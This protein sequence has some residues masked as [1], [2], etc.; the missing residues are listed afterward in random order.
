MG[1]TLLHG[2]R[3]RSWT[4]LRGPGVATGGRHGPSGTTG[5][6]PGPRGRLPVTAVRHL[7]LHVPFC[8]HRCPYCD[9]PVVAGA[10]PGASRW[11]SALASELRLR[12]AAGLDLSDLE[13]LLVGGGTPSYLRA[14]LVEGVEAIVGA[15]R[16]GGLSEWTVEVN[17]EDVEGELLECWCEAGVT[18][19]HI[20][21]QSLR[22]RALEWL[23]RGHSP[24][25][26]LA[27]MAAAERAGVRSWGVDVLFGLPLEFD[28]DPTLTLGK[29]I[30]AGAPHVSLYELA[31]EPGTPL[32]AQRRR[33]R[34]VPAGD[35]LVADQY[36]AC[37][38]VLG[39]AGYE[40]YEMTSFA[41]PSHRPLH[42]S[43]VLRE[44]P[45]LGLGPGAHSRVGG[46]HLRNL[47]EWQGY[48]GAVEGRE[49]PHTSGVPVDP[50]SPE[51]LWFRL[52][53]AEGIRRAELGPGGRAL[54]D[55]WIERGL[56]LDD[57]SSLRLGPAGWLRLDELSD[58]LAR[59]EG[60]PPGRS[61][62]H[63]LPHVRD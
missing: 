3:V 38:E 42:M 2:G 58:A 52:R 24:R 16:I 1:E 4:G 37:H 25:R 63:R 32:E 41:R 29:V 33:G 21:V 12:E 19:I 10:S 20:G 40:A 15:E 22:S 23:G 44:E 13:T 7:Y 28:L 46:S 51:A 14:G 6:T 50:G 17:P 39:A 55:A 27:A 57:R 11:A 43:A 49:L 31:L 26:A 34:F 54:A 60:E 35:D 53:R 18:R 30:E 9:Y 56:A 45:W 8:R 48:L 47:R 36:L 59:A 5:R 62:L 61:S